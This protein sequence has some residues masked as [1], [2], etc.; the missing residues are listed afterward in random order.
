[1]GSK[2]QIDRLPVAH[3]GPILALDWC[4]PDGGVASSGGWVASGSLDRTVKVW[5]LT[6]PH[7]ERTPAYTLT[8]QFPIRRIRWRPGYECE[9]AVASNADIGC[10]VSD[11]SDSGVAE[12]VD[13]EKPEVAIPKRRADM[14]YAVEIW[15]VRRGYIAKWL[16]GGSAIEGGV[17]GTFT[18][19]AW[20]ELGLT[21]ADI[22]FRDSHALWAQHSSGTFAQL[23]LRNSYRPLDAVPRLAASWSVTHSLT[24]VTDK[25]TQWEVP[26]DDM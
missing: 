6:G 8:T 24:F 4:T 3:S 15:D 11:L 22:D 13:L 12:D 16:V 18:S 26:Y 7:F 2:G 19:S 23:D 20:Q 5:D 25:K 10:A 14:G 21:F 17:T 9:I 1:M